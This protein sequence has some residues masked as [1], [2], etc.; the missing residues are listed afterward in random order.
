MVSGLG[1]ANI[2]FAYLAYFIVEVIEP[3]EDDS[4]PTR[5]VKDFKARV[6]YFFGGNQRSQPTEG[7][8]PTANSDDK[9]GAMSRKSPDSRSRPS[10]EIPS[11]LVHCNESPAHVKQSPNLQNRNSH[12]RS[13]TPSIRN[14]GEQENSPE[15]KKSPNHRG[16]RLFAARL[17]ILFLAAM[18]FRTNK[19]SGANFLIFVFTA[20]YAPVSRAIADG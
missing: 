9:R 13:S 1:V 7:R 17:V 4:R 10:S 5:A 15:F 16:R 12:I 19:N 11:N 14:Q 2:I 18:M 20:C 6:S 8:A 3:G